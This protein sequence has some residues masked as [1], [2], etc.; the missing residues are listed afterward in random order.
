MTALI[1]KLF[2][3]SVLNTNFIALIVFIFSVNISWNTLRQ[4]SIT[5]KKLT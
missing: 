1:W 5:E 3:N 4:E 2:V